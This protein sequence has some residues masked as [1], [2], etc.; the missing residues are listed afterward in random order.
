M[1]ITRVSSDFIQEFAKGLKEQSGDLYDSI[2]DKEEAKKIIEL[3]NEYSE[4]LVQTDE[5]KRERAETLQ[6]LAEIK[7]EQKRLLNEVKKESERFETMY[8]ETL[9]K[10][11][12]E[13][14]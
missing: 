10:L 4:L 14:K 3:V 2:E 9:E 6:E 8:Q 13:L 1:Q 11:N 12:S 5:A 7:K